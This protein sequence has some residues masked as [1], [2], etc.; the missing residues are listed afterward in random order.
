[1]SQDKK[2]YLPAINATSNYAT[3][4]QSET[5]RTQERS[6]LAERTLM[7]TPQSKKGK[8]VAVVENAQSKIKSPVASKKR[9]NT[10]KLDSKLS[11]V[12]SLVTQQTIKVD[13]LAN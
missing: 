4:Q 11:A 6:R 7:N 3:L 5:S 2:I 9:H 13:Q 1:M 12:N 8:T 10:L